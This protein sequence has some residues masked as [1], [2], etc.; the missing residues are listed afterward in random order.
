MLYHWR[1]IFKMTESELCTLSTVHVIMWLW[2]LFFSN[3]YCTFVREYISYTLLREQER[4]HTIQEPLFGSTVTVSREH[5]IQICLHSYNRDTDISPCPLQLLRDLHWVDSVVLITKH[6]LQL[7]KSRSLPYRTSS[8]FCFQVKWGLRQQGSR[9]G[10]S[11]QETTAQ[12]FGEADNPYVQ[13]QPEW[14][15]GIAT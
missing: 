13:C 15:H 7:S 2:T 10:T 3:I 5:H 12:E 11:A 6:L 1:N 9:S 14:W 4:V 8:L